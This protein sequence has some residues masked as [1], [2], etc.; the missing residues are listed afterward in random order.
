MEC[1]NSLEVTDTKLLKVL[2][3]LF[4]KNVKMN[5]FR[6]FRMEMNIMEHVNPDQFSH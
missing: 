1:N 3:N 4:K 6:K 2:E 5:L